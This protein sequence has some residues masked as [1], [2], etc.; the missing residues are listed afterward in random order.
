MSAPFPAAEPGKVSPT[1]APLAA[2]PNSVFPFPPE[3][4]D[5]I[6]SAM[7]ESR[8][9]VGKLVH[10]FMRLTQDVPSDPATVT[11]VLRQAMV[12]KDT[13]VQAFL[14]PHGPKTFPITGESETGKKKRARLAAAAKLSE[15]S[16]SEA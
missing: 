4:K 14:I 3:Q 10:D 2:L 15:E 6:S 11:L 1:H 9:I 8:E 5:D 16:K 13:M 7:D 12:L